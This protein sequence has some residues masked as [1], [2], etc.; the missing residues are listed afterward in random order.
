MSEF[1]NGK[2]TNL[3]LVKCGKPQGTILGPLPDLR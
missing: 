2:T 1:V 3:L